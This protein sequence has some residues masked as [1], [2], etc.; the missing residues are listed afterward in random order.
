MWWGCVVQVCEGRMGSLIL[1]PLPRGGQHVYLRDI[2]RAD[3]PAFYLGAASCGCS[4][5]SGGVLGPGA[6]PCWCM[7]AGGWECAV[8]GKPL[9][10]PFAPGASSVVLCSSVPS[11]GGH[12]VFC[13]YVLL[14]AFCLGQCGGV[15]VLQSP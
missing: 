4:S 6:R 10:V 2:L 1:P 9:L 8:P 3:P 5:L 13:P 15:V 12:W 7:G 11:C 14:V